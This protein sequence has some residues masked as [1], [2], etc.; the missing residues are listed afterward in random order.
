MIK[1]D[2]LYNQDQLIDVQKLEPGIYLVNMRN[3]LGS[4]VYTGK[5]LKL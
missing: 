5:L 1:N 3:N 2:L 4:I